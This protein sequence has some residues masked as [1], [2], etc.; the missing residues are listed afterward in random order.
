MQKQLDRLEDEVIFNR[1]QKRKVFLV[2]DNSGRALDNVVQP[3]EGIM[4]IVYKL[5]CY[6]WWCRTV[7]WFQTENYRFRK[8]PRRPED[9]FRCIQIFQ[10]LV[11]YKNSEIWKQK[12]QND[13]NSSADILILK[14]PAY[15]IWH[16]NK[17]HRHPHN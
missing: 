2:S 3:L 13:V 5:W 7:S 11:C 9:I 17:Y 16:Y 12:S 10:H 6:N 1:V 4:D 15:S 14:C 8:W